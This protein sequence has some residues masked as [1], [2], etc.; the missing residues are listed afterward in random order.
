MDDFPDYHWHEEDIPEEAA[1]PPG[2]SWLRHP[3]GVAGLGLVLMVAACVAMPFRLEDGET[4][5]RVP[6]QI[7]FLFGL[8]ITLG[9]T[10]WWYQ[11]VHAEKED[12]PEE[13]N[14]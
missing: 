1:R 12:D 9:G 13:G 10:V 2:H 3:F 5:L 6:G 4:P 7:V 14:R 11:Q 8:L